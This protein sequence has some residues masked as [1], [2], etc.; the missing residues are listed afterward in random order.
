MSSNPSTRTTG[1]HA[2]TALSRA[3][4][5]AWSYIKNPKGDFKM[6]K[7]QELEILHIKNR[8]TLLSGRGKDN[9]KIIKKLQRRLRALTATID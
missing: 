9:G 2:A 4:K 1:R 8:I 5:V 7:T 6:L 3:E